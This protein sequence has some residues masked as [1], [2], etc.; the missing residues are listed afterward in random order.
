[1]HANKL[2]FSSTNCHTCTGQHRLHNTKHQV[3]V[4]VP[5]G[6]KVGEGRVHRGLERK[7]ERKM[8]SLPPPPPPQLRVNLRPAADRGG[9]WGVGQVGWGVCQLLH[10]VNHKVIWGCTQPSQVNIHSDI[11]PIPTVIAQMES[12]SLKST[13]ISQME[14]HSL[15]ST[16]ISQMESQSMKSTVISQMESHSLKWLFI[17]NTRGRSH[18]LL[19]TCTGTG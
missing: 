13:V 9:K 4:H 7:L 8:L 3:A 5:Q 12:H 6:R 2:E 19:F 1:M 15:K 17:P 14:S 18:L 16:V 11:F 10:P